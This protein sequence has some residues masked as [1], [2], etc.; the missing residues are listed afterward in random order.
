[1]AELDE[2]ARPVVRA[3]ARFHRYEARRH[4]RHEAQE[5]RAAQ[6]AALLTHAPGIHA[7]QLKH[8]LCQIDRQRRNLVHGPIL[9]VSLRRLH[10]LNLGPLLRKAVRG[11]WVHTIRDVRRRAAGMHFRRVSG[12]ASRAERER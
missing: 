11:G 1:M 8:V 12:G 2:L 10:A 7:M 6:P 9:L 4:L 5:L 3:R